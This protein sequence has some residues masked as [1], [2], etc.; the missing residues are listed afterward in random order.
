MNSLGLYC[1]V[2]SSIGI[3]TCAAQH[4]GRQQLQNRIVGGYDAEEGAWPWQ[5]DIQSTST[6]RHVCGG[7]LIA[8]QWV[9]SAAHCFPNPNDLDAYIIYIGR[10]QLNGWNP[11]EVSRRIERVVVPSEYVDPQEGDDI[12]LLQLDSEVTWSER[13]Q[14]ICLPGPNTLFP[15]G[16]RCTVT[17]WGDIRDG[18]SLQGAG[19]LQQVQLPIIGQS[20]CQSMYDT[21]ANPNDGVTIMSDM[22]C[23]GYQAGGKDSCQGDSGGPL[24]CSMVNN[25]WVQAGIVSFGLGCAQ[26]NRPGVY[27]RVSSF[28]GFIQRT[29]PTLRLYGSGT[30]I[31]GG[32]ALAT[33]LA[34]VLTLLM[35]TQVLR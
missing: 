17:G 20:S 16:L 30:R 6:N 21:N 15:S 25:T 8:E 13:I 22:V 32:A 28:S 24:V 2:L 33:V 3:L 26:P 14:P 9:L 1:A 27:A 18:V 11:F 10:H 31:H 29:I 12:A 4:C 7:T 19:T 34:S 35:V 5:V 23:A